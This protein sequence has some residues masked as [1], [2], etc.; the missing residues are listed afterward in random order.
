MTCPQIVRLLLALI[1]AVPAIVI[2]GE[3]R[4][5][6]Q[7]KDRPEGYPLWTSRQWADSC[8]RARLSGS[9]KA[10]QEFCEEGFAGLKPKV[11]LLPGGTEVELLDAGDCRDLAYVRVLTGTLKGEV[12]CVAAPALSSF[13]PE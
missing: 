3:L 11:G 10:Q 8:G 6:V 1:L 13:K 12:G 4:Y 5:V 9:K 2:A 7:H